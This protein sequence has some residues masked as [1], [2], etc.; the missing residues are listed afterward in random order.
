MQSMTISTFHAFQPT[1]HDRYARAI[2]ASK[3]VRWDLEGDVIRGRRLEAT[4][5][6]LPDGLT[7]SGELDF[8]NEAELRF[9]SQIQ[10]RTYANMF[11]MVERFVNAKVLQLTQRHTLQDQVALEALVRFSD[12]ELK[13]QQLF[14]RVEMLAARALP[15]G[16]R[17]VP[18]AN[19]VAGLVLQK[20]NWSVLALTC[21][22]E[23]L[24]QAHYKESIAPDGSL[25]EFFR[26]I[27]RFHW[28]EESQH[29]VLDELEWA[30]E[31]AKLTPEARAV[32][33]SDLIELVQA[34]DGVLGLQAAEDAAYFLANNGR[35]LSPEQG[36][37]VRTTFLRA[38]RHTYVFSGLQMTRYPEILQGFLSEAEFARIGAALATLR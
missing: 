5:K 28:M 38:Y 24:T 36:A 9:Y 22:I 11:G 17:F 1:A 29:A 26:D 4:Q 32:A 13:H 19:E 23:L 34:V 20:S 31:D 10:G 18:S 16:Y 3:R 8:L 14:E 6:F 2:A 25:S 33:V 30:A 15:D 37:R 12:E 21:L 7:L 27:F 35:V